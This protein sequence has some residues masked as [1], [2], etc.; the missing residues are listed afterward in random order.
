VPVVYFVSP[1]VWAWRPGRVKG[2]RRLVRRML[3]LFPFETRF[4]AEAGVPVTF[5]GHPVAEPVGEAPSREKLRANAG[6]DPDRRTVALMPGSRRV[7]VERLLPLLLEAGRLLARERDGLQF[8]VPVAPGRTDDEI[9]ALVAASGLDGV[10][11]HRGEFPQILTACDAGVVSAGTASLEAAVTGLPIVVVYRMN[12]FSYLLGRAL[13][14]VEHVALP[15][16]VAGRQVVPELIQ[17]E[18][19]P[20][21]IADELARY[22]D[23]P[24]HAREVH[25]TLVGLRARLGGG[26]IY[27]RAADAILA[28]FAVGQGR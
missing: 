7:E 28:E 24:G 20:R 1:Q 26:G 10:R 9:D 4:Y 25:E 18:C 22:L 21:R 12:L 16:L 19:T 2:I 15:N 11:T 3:V 6:L 8:L 23:D 14:Q 13:V 27:D 5:V 17:R